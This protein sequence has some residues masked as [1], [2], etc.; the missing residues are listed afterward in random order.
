M[1]VSE[2]IS[3]INYALRGVDDDAPL[4][5]DDD[6][7]QWLSVLNSKKDD[8]ANDVKQRWAATFDIKSVATVV[9]AG[10][11][12]YDLP[13]DFI[14]PSDEVYVVDTNG[15][16]HSFTLIK[17]QQ[18]QRNGSGQVFISGVN[19]K[20]L[21][22]SADITADNPLIGGTIQAPGYYRPAD[23]TLPTNELPFDD[24]NWA[25]M[26]AAAEIAFNDVVYETKAADLT[27]KAN[28][29]YNNMAKAN[30]VLTYGNARTV[31]YNNRQ[32]ITSPGLR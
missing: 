26:A 29:L 30:R 2:A 9:A 13:A 12:T 14:A 17:P 32:Q 15:Q 24:P 25:V 20:K 31:P 19:P 7:N 11:Q 6:Y 3:K 21:N 16:R 1:F 23:M 10:T 8:Y 18:R 27:E 4:V 5:G 22:F 28:E